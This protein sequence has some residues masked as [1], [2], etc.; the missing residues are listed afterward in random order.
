MSNAERRAVVCQE[1]SIVPRPSDVYAA[2]PSIT[3]KMELEY[4][5]ELM[6]ADKVA[7][8][9]VAK[10]AGDTFRAWGGEAVSDDLDAVV[11]Y[12]DGGSVL[13]LGETAGSRAT[14]GGVHARC[15]ML[16]NVVRELALARD[17]SAAAHGGRVRAGARGARGGPHGYR[18]PIR[19]VTRGRRG[20]RRP[21]GY[22]RNSGIEA[23]AKARARA[24]GGSRRRGSRGGVV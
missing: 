21:G 3:G 4:E 18:A 1:P 13:Q 20:G 5:G 11:A 17:N 7:R 6:G 24:R 8:E 14:H 22:L 2:L 23:R 9:L 10:A 12:F 16:T 15:R 19:D